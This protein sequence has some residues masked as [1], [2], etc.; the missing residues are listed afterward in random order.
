MRTVH[1]LFVVSVM[2]FISGIVFVVAAARPT[3]RAP[4]PAASETPAVTPVATVKQIMRGIVAPAA[5]VVFD[6]VST[7]VSASGVEENQP[8]TDEEWATVASSAAALVESGNLLVM[9]DRAIDR[10]E[11]VKMSRALID[12]GNA[13]LK[14]AES[15]SPQGILDTG[16]AINTSCDNCHER[17]WRQ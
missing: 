16:E 14:A 1:W 11:W 2:L 6:S 8:R 7:I 4:V 15:K 10:G 9:G 17:Y 13:A 5:T 3:M 12:A